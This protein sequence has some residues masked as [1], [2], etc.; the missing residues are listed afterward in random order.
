MKIT[1]MRLLLFSTAAVLLVACGG[2]AEPDTEATAMPTATAKI[3]QATP[4][5]TPAPAPNP[6]PPTP[7]STCTPR[8]FTYSL[9]KIPGSL[10]HSPDATWWGYNQSKIARY[11]DTVHTVHTVTE[12]IF[13][14]SALLGHY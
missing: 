13:L 11:G 10:N 14:Y 1:V 3:A 2:S 9:E 5:A 6:V 12:S 7:T 4:T 8:D